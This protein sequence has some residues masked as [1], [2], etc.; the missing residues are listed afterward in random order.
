MKKTTKLNM[1]PGYVTRPQDKKSKVNKLNADYQKMESKNYKMGG[2]KFPDL[3][4]D[5][6]VTQADILKGRGVFKAGGAKKNWIKGAIKNPGAFSAKAKAAGMSTAAY[7]AKVT[8]PGSKASTTTK[9]QA[10]L[11]KTLGK[12]RSKKG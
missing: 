2:S 10:N 8:K 4:G 12:M 9:R 6:K 5:G 1:N 11:A 7:A 3:T